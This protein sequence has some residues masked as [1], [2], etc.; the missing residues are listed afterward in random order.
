MLRDAVV[1]IAGSFSG[2]SLNAHRRALADDLEC[3]HL[4]GGSRLNLFMKL[5]QSQYR[6]AVDR[7]SIATTPSPARKPA[8][9]LDRRAEIFV[10]DRTRLDLPQQSGNFAS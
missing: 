8:W 5:L 6:Q 4:P 2:L 10:L 3:H 9:S 7:L 1:L